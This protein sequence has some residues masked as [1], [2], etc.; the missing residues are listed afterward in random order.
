MAVSPDLYLRGILQFVPRQNRLR[1][2]KI[3]NGIG[4]VIQWWLIGQLLDMISVGL[5]VTIGL[6][7]LGVPLAMTL[8]LLAGLL[9]FVPVVD[10]IVSAVPAILIALT[11]SPYKALS[12]AILF[13]WKD[14]CRA[15]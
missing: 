13:C 9:D 12:V 4:D 2:R 7:L 5:M 8:G 10:A 14:T 15:R 3:I 11:V 1:A 6:W